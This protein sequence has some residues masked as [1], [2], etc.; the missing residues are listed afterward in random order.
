MVEITVLFAD[1]SSIHRTDAG[2]RRGKN[3]PSGRCLFT[4]WPPTCWS[5]YGAFIDKYVGDAVMALFNV[6][7]RY[8][9]HA[10]RAAEAAK[11]LAMALPTLGRTVWPFARSFRRHRHWLCPRRPPRLR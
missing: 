5:R 2:T 3:P 4:L 11:E 8:E 9:D 1:L 7:I 6:P 10:L